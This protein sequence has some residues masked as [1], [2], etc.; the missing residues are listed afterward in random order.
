MTAHGLR[1]EGPLELG[2]E[3]NSFLLAA[4]RLFFFHQNTP[5]LKFVELRSSSLTFVL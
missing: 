5:S 1:Q 2:L 4:F 3:V